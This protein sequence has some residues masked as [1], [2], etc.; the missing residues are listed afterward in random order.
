M[1]PD[2]YRRFFTVSYT[3]FFCQ[4]LSPKR[5]FGSVTRVNFLQVRSKK[6]TFAARSSPKLCVDRFSR[7][8]V[9][10]DS[11]QYDGG[12]RADRRYAFQWSLSPTKDQ[13]VSCSINWLWTTL[14]TRRIFSV[15]ER[16]TVDVKLQ[17]ESL[18][19]PLGRLDLLMPTAPSS[20]M[21]I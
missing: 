17:G 18:E 20:F 6:D 10:H 21:F 11:L 4:I 14:A 15:K 12:R 8:G 1:L 3:E 16:G 13:R 9:A 2:W 5:D 19:I 7:Q